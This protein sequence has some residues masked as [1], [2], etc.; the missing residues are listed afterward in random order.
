MDVNEIARRYRARQRGGDIPKLSPGPK[1]GYKQTPEHIAK[2]KRFGENNHNWKGD[3]AIT[4]SG[5]SRAERLFVQKQPCSKCGA[6]GVRIDRHHKDNN[7]LNNEPCNIEFLCRKCHME[8]D[9]RLN[10]FIELAKLNQPKAVAA[11][12]DN[13]VLQ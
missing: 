7:T 3:N 9:G 6:S 11:R 1:M 10:G 5:R 13:V 8:V 12:W 2:R 4:R